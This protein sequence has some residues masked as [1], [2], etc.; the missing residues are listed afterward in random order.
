MLIAFLY[1][2][3]MNGVMKSA[4]FPYVGNDLGSCNVNSATACPTQISG[5]LTMPSANE[6]LLRDILASYGP[7]PVAIDA[8]N[9]SFFS[10]SSGIYYEPACN[11]NYLTHAM[12]LVGKTVSHF[13]NKLR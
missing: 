10:Y 4:G 9:D 3:G 5:V 8:S 11:P 1:V 7:L 2:K 12:L 13:L 6:T